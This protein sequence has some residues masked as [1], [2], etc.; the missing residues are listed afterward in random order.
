MQLISTEFSTLQISG[1]SLFF[2]SNDNYWSPLAGFPIAIL[3]SL[4]R[5]R[6]SDF[7]NLN[8]RER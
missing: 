8:K 7:N 6:D 3:F 2:I 1:I 4:K 5:I